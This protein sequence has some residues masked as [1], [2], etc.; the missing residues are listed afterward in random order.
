LDLQSMRL[1][2][3]R[4]WRWRGFEN[5]SFYEIKSSAFSFS[6][7]KLSKVVKIIKL[8]VGSGVERTVLYDV[9]PG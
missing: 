7:H 8:S 5:P 6:F 3:F 1:L 4:A 2:H 9:D